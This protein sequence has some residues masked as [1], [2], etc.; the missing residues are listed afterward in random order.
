MRGSAVVKRRAAGRAEGDEP[1]PAEEGRGEGR[2]DAERDWG[3][4][5][6][7]PFAR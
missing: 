3:D 4:G 6:A 2:E 5:A 1:A 7:G